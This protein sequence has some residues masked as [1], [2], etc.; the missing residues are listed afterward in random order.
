MIVV[1]AFIDWS[2]KH[3]CV[4]LGYFLSEEYWG[5]GIATEALQEL[6][7]Y[8]FNELCLNRIEGRSD[9]D[10]FGSQKVMKKLG[11]N[12]EGTLRKNEF[13]KDEYRDTEV[14]SILESEY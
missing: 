14:Y 9:T 6:V 12:Y 7:R 3:N 13:I 2:N 5:Q 4:E 10:N 8:G 11:M 1:A